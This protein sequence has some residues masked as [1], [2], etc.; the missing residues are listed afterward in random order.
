MSWI[1]SFMLL[2]LCR[3]IV[4]HLTILQQHTPKTT[5]TRGIYIDGEMLAT[6]K[7]GQDRSIYKLM[8]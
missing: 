8:L 5:H 2:Q 7:Q 6:L 1:V 4:N 3:V